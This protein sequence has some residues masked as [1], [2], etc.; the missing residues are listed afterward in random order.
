MHYIKIKVGH[1]NTTNIVVLVHVAEILSCI[2]NQM[3][4]IMS[5]SRLYLLRFMYS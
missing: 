3:F 2:L 1:F 5:F 4:Y